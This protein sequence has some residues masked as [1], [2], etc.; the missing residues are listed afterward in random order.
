MQPKPPLP[1]FVSEPRIKGISTLASLIQTGSPSPLTKKP[2]RTL[3]FR[4]VDDAKDMVFLQLFMVVRDVRYYTPEQYRWSTS[5]IFARLS[6]DTLGY[7]HSAISGRGNHRLSVFSPAETAQIVEL[8]RQI[9]LSELGDHGFN[10]AL[11]RVF[12]DA[13]KSR[14]GDYPAGLKLAP[15]ST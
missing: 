9:V 4:P 10:Q 2:I 5:P 7:C 11:H 6:N 1:L 13:R 3:R 12:D 14:N 8:L 15:N